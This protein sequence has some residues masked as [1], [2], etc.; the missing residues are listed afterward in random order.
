MYG[1]LNRPL[2]QEWS[3]QRYVHTLP[4]IYFQKLF[5]FLPQHNPKSP[6]Q[7]P[8]TP[9]KY[10][11]KFR[12]CTVSRFPPIWMQQ[13]LEMLH[14]SLCHGVRMSQVRTIQCLQITIQG[15][16]MLSVWRNENHR[17][18]SSSLKNTNNKSERKAQMVQTS[19]WYGSFSSL[20]SSA[21]LQML[22]EDFQQELNY[23]H[24]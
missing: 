16:Q 12:L 17:L 1:P 11:I 4:L 13:Q 21:I 23:F 9:D 22:K 15:L 14:L 19:Y 20:A 8:K 3:K 2:M 6:K 5:Q 18:E 7:G 10:D 24:S